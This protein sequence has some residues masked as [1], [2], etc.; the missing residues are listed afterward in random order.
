MKVSMKYGF[1][2]LAGIF[3]SASVMA[4]EPIEDRDAFEK[5]YIKCVISG[6]KDN[7]LFNLL[8]KHLTPATK[9]DD[10]QILDILRSFGDFYKDKPPAY[11]V[12]VVDKIMR[13]GIVESRTYMIERTD[14]V[15]V[16]SYINFIKIKDGWYIN[17]FGISGADEVIERILQL[18]VYR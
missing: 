5:H 9:E 10:K 1:S 14:G 13:A 16:G 8:S 15:F 4:S 12:H 17:S 18:P 2:L 6:L 7:C 3:L 11:K